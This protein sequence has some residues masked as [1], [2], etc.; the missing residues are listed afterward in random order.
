MLEGDLSKRVQLENLDFR[1]AATLDAMPNT[2]PPSMSAASILSANAPGTANVNPSI[3]NKAVHPAQH[4]ASTMTA[5]VNRSYSMANPAG[6]KQRR[7]SEGTLHLS[8]SLPR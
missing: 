2:N 6:P 1:G 7:T 4:A 8:K 3:A 5:S